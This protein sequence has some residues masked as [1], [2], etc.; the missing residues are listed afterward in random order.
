[1]ATTP[2]SLLRPSLAA[3]QGWQR[4]RRPHYSTRTYR[5]LW[6]RPGH[7]GRPSEDIASV[8][9]LSD[10][11]SWRE[12]SMYWPL[13]SAVLLGSRRGAPASCATGSARVS[14][15]NGWLEAGPKVIGMAVSRRQYQRPLGSRFLWCSGNTGAGCWACWWC[16]VLAARCSTRTRC[17]GLVSG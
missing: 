10:C 12:C 11:A 9:C 14:S 15:L 2:C 16:K 3:A 13:G 1:M 5:P 8:Y 17:A 6:Q 4:R 7:E